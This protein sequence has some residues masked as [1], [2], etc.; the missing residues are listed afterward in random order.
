MAKNLK[1]VLPSSTRYISEKEIKT[2]SAAD[3]KTILGNSVIEV[4]F[5]DGSKIQYPESIFNKL[6]SDKKY[7]LSELR[8][9]VVKVVA[10]KILAIMLDSEIKTS[11]IENLFQTIQQSLNFSFDKA[12]EILWGKSIYERTLYDADKIIKDGKQTS[13]STDGVGDKSDTPDKV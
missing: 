1:S 12:D 6:V 11:Y 2:T 9:R 4:E 8:D 5:E 3:R 10:E 13:V 7:D